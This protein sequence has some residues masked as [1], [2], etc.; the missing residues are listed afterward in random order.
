MVRAVSAFVS[1][2]L[3]LWSTATAAATILMY[4]HVDEAMPAITSVTPD[5]FAGHLRALKREGFLVLRLDTLLAQVAAG[6]PAAEKRVAITFDDAYRSIYD[7]ALPLLEHYGWQATVFV[8]TDAVG[9]G[10]QALT[11]AMLQDMQRRG[12]LLANHSRSHAHLVRRGT[13]ES[14]AEWRHRVLDDIH[15]AAAQLQQ[16]LGSAPPPWFAYPYG[17]QNSALRALLKAQGLLGFGQHSGAIDAHTDWQNIPRVAVNQ[18]YA[19]WTSLRDKLLALPLPVRTT[20]PADGVT[21]DPSPRLVLQLPGDWQRR[22]LRCF[23]SGE[24]IAPTITYDGELS[25][26]T[27]VSERAL[28][29]GRS[30]YTCTAPAANGRYYWYSWLWMRRGAAG[31]WYKE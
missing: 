12:H 4:H 27:L 7:Q 31:Q 8:N 30:R 23:I 20:Q 19:E 10:A 29:I 18:H 11:V 25:T 22:Q 24:P 26:L 21:D 6:L 16:W 9:R 28:P 2:T 15:G 17:E 1:M 13:D 3:L 14:E 5:Q